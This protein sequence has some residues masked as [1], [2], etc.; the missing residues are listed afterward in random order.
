MTFRKLSAHVLTQREAAIK[1]A[2]GGGD[3]RS[4]L[5]ARKGSS[6]YE[7]R[8]T[9][10]KEEDSK[11]QDGTDHPFEAQKRSSSFCDRDANR[12]MRCR[13]VELWEGLC[14]LVGKRRGMRR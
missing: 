1:A 4:R 13:R 3:S 14:T 7:R 11:D 12:R 6:G 5:R 10:S 2:G 8:G 9:N